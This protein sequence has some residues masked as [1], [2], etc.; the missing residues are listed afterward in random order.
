MSVNRQQFCSSLNVSMGFVLVL[1]K[2]KLSK[3]GG[4]FDDF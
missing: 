4:K 2:P 1:I 3:D